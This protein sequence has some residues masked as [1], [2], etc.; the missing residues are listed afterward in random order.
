METV[1]RQQKRPPRILE[2]SWGHIEV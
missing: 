1:V 2:I